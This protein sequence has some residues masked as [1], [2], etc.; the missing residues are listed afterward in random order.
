MGEGD[1]SEVSFWLNN[2]ND[3]FSDFDHRDY[4]Q[5]A[6]SDDFL[7]EAKRFT[8]EKKSGR[9]EVRFLLP[10]KLRHKKEEH[11]IT[12]RLHEH[13]KHYYQ[14]LL[15]D[16]RHT[17]RQGMMLTSA[18]ILFMAGAALTTAYNAAALFRVVLEPGGWFM[19]WM[20]LDLVFIIPHHK[21]ADLEF[22][23]KISKCEIIFGEQ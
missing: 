1:G 8:R 19:T 14:L 9:L 10:S 2:Y 16:A 6:V 3:L 22:Y 11:I 18:G 20:G 12:R 13:F 21:K 4:S 7:A 17:R 5:R 23:E 15:A